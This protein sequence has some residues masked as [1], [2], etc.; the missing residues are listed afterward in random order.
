MQT[1]QNHLHSLF[2]SLQTANFLMIALLMLL[3]NVLFA[4]MTEVNVK[5]EIRHSWD[6]DIITAYVWEPNQ[7][8]LSLINLTRI[9][10][11]NYFLSGFFYSLRCSEGA[12]WVQSFPYS[13]FDRGLY[14]TVSYMKHYSQLWTISYNIIILISYSH[15]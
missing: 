12:F 15:F 6:D 8:L 11:D 5:T 14:F 4:S 7:Q 2:H 9:V 13:I 10:S 3:T 1:H